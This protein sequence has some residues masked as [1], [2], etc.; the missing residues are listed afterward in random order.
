MPFKISV[1][2]FGFLYSE[3]LLQ[4]PKAKLNIITA[5]GT[6]PFSS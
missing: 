2:P 6:M 1:V 4:R 5:V 3:H